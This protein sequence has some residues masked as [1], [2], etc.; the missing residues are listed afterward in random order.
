MVFTILTSLNGFAGPNLRKAQA[1]AKRPARRK[2]QSQ[3]CKKDA[4]RR[5]LKRL[6]AIPVPVDFRGRALFL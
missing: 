6:A 2:P 4:A 1:S 3:L 5:L